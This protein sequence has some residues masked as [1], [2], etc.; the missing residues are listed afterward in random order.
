M[1]CKYC[2]KELDEGVTVCPYCGESQ[3]ETTTGKQLKRMQ[4]ALA[5]FVGVI[6]LI[7]LCGVVHYGVTGSFLPRKNDLHNKLSYTVSLEKLE[8]E[9]GYKA[10]EKKLD[11]VVAT[12]GDHKLTNRMLQVY[13]WELVGKSTYKDLD[14]SSPLD[15]QY[16]DPDT[17]T[18]W[19]QFFIQQAI[20]VWVQ[21]MAQVDA[22]AAAGYQMP[23]DYS[24]QFSTLQ[25]DLEKMITANG[26]ASPEAYLDM[27]YGKGVDFQTFYDYR[28]NYYYGG[29]YCED[30]AQNLEVTQDQIEAYFQAHAE[31]L[32]SGKY[33]IKITKDSG[34]LV[35]VRHIL[36]KITG[37]TKDENGQIVYTEEDWEACRAKAQA[38]LD[39]WMAGDKTEDSFAKLATE[40]TEDG[41]SKQT[42]GLYESVYKGQMVEPFETWCFDEIR[43]KGDTGLVKTTYGYHVMYYVSGEEGWIMV[44]REGAKYMAADAM[45]EQIRNRND[46]K[47]NYRNIVIGEME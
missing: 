25:A 20:D 32:A 14:K 7:L 26:F 17:Q 27:Y 47:I 8:T 12:F 10:Y 34:K 22:A 30:Y 35:D 39:A 42:G 29:L 38:I 40:K 37:E 18:T 5:S 23:E 16:Q 2:Q 45:V 43:Q 13:F 33:G 41:G 4:I 46:L 28:W 11:K 36:V 6:L 21:D 31:E 3:E 15:L 9:S 19:E 24:S 44:S 1:Q